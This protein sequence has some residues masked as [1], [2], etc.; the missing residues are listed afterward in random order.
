MIS[1]INKNLYI[2]LGP[3]LAKFFL[4]SSN[5]PI[6]LPTKPIVNIIGAIKKITKYEIY[7]IIFSFLLIFLF[8]NDFKNCRIKKLLFSDNKTDFSK[9]RFKIRYY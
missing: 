9:I 7:E 2:I 5:K 1:I 4:S 8:I 3:I 6:R